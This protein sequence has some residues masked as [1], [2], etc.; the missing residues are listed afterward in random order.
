MSSP[1]QQQYPYLKVLT[2]DSGRPDLP[3]GV[4]ITVR[5]YLQDRDDMVMGHKAPQRFGK[6]SMIHA[7]SAELRERG[8]PITFVIAP[9]TFLTKQLVDKEKIARSVS[10]YGMRLSRPLVV[11]RI[12][13][14]QSSAFYVRDKAP[15]TL[16][17]MTMGLVHYGS[18]LDNILDAVNIM[19]DAPSGMPPAFIIDEVHLIALKK[20]WG[21]TL[22]KIAES[23]AFVVGLT[24]TPRR[25][26]KSPIPG[27]SVV[28][29]N[30]EEGKDKNVYKGLHHIEAGTRIGQF[31]VRGT[32]KAEFRVVPKH[33]IDVP[34]SKAFEE[35][36]LNP[37]NFLPVNVDV[38]NRETGEVLP[39]SEVPAEELSSNLEHWLK[40]ETLIRA[41][42]YPALD[43][44]NELRKRYEVALA[45]AKETARQEEPSGAKPNPSY[46][47]WLK[48]QMLI[49]SSK[50]SESSQQKSNYHA[51]EIRR[52]LAEIL[53]SENSE[54]FPYLNNLSIEIATSTD[55]DGA[56]DAKSEDKIKDF[57]KGLVDI[58]IVKTMGLV[59]LDAPACKVQINLSSIR[60]GPLSDQMNTRT[61]TIW[62]QEGFKDVCSV[63]FYPADKASEKMV[64]NLRKEQ[65]KVVQTNEL[66]D[67]FL[68]PL[69]EKPV[70]EYLLEGGAI[71]GYRDP[72]GGTV[73]G[74]YEAIL[75]AIKQQ[76]P[77][78][79]T[80][81]DTTLIQMYENGTLRID[82]ALLEQKREEVLQ[83]TESVRDLDEELKELRGRFGK[84]AQKLTRRL[85]SP[86]EDIEKYRT[87]VRIL[88]SKAKEKCH[89]MQAVNTI[90]DPDVLNELI[91]ALDDAYKDML[92]IAGEAYAARAF[93]NVSVPHTNG[94]NLP[95]G[96]RF[97]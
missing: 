88:Q 58:L 69:E 10:L 34:I 43:R 78:L 51:R 37:I 90:D 17:S 22:N 57:T 93:K 29:E 38:R 31:E 85:A 40:S 52:I 30:E 26:D 71:A 4:D 16:A 70:N 84:K 50:D 97:S 15:L 72:L 65:Q 80:L 3:L 11:Q 27:F 9:W 96:P 33:G 18:N 95:G 68:A 12:E 25:L 79:S 61:G 74:D 49:V 86:Q 44:L 24:G 35:K 73:E 83:E 76:T 64:E 6:A 54:R 75:K 1:F 46:L 82:E 63:C 45:K 28:L 89:V 19:L 87:Y 42:A 7:I 77:E 55:E 53:R 13:N 41:M 8:C 94:E 2:K 36:W 60:K 62:D 47:T 32:T 39:L 81:L 59:G 20:Q 48:P 66:K 21:E 91:D 5:R 56:P 14:I 67:E 23:G 92:N